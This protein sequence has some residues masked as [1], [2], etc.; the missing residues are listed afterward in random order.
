MNSYNSA[1]I[2]N[3]NE[4]KVGVS[5]KKGGAGVSYI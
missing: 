5:V 4:K 2:A 3:L 1:I